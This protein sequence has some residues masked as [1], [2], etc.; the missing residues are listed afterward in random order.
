MGEDSL[1]KGEPVVL[2]GGEK[3]DV[4]P[5][6]SRSGRPPAIPASLGVGKAA[7]GWKGMVLAER[8]LNWCIEA[9]RS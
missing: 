3:S 4:A 1:F 6:L 8:L 9:I 5:S 7:C 2:Q